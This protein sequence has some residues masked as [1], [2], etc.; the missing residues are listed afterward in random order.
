MRS[1]FTFRK[2]TENAFFY[3]FSKSLL[4]GK[5]KAD[6]AIEIFTAILH[7][8]VDE[9]FHRLTQVNEE[10][11]DA[12]EFMYAFLELLQRLTLEL[13]IPQVFGHT[14]QTIVTCRF[15]NAERSPENLTSNIWI[16]PVLE[17]ADLSLAN[18]IS[19]QADGEELNNIQYDQCKKSC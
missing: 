13:R 4:S 3:D 15:F 12:I 11:E 10:E 19:R 5:F 7:F 17:Q 2:P 9:R 16:I 1:I 8:P 14:Q 6:A 18:C